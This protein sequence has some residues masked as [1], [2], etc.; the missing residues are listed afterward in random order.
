[1]L[2]ALIRSYVGFMFLVYRVL[3]K[4]QVRGLENVPPEGPFILSSNEIGK[5]GNLLI[6]FVISK[7]VL[8]G[9]MKKPVGFLDE[10]ALTSPYGSLFR[11]FGARPIFPHGRGQAVAAL[12]S[13]LQS[14]REGEI[15]AM[16]PEAQTSLDGRLVPPTRAVAW[17]ALRTG[18]PVV[19]LVSTKGA[20]DVWPAWSNRPQFTGR[21]QV[22]VGKPL[23]LSDAPCSRVNDQMIA[24]A[25]RRIMEEMTALIYQ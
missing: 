12:L 15:L 23:Y 17:L 16:N 4:V 19:F 11:Q 20:Y 9:H 6:S 24:T 25:N 10:Y 3:Y 7:L 21:F 13:A 2:Y 1:M 5:M 14:L 18:A 22:R 8:G